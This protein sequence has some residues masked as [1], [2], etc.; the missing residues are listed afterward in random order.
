LHKWVAWYDDGSVYKSSEAKW[1]DLP[2]DGMQ[3]LHVQHD[4]VTRTHYGNDYY[5][6]AES[7]N[8]YIYAANDHPPEETE[9]RY[10][11][12]IIK[13]GRWMEQKAFDALDKKAREYGANLH[14]D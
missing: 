2:D 5:F 11:N 1:E 13:R 3:Y 4:E 14:P 7:E 8:G 10:V 6:R 12:A 9:K